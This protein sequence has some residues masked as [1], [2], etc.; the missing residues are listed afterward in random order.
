MIIA[1][2]IHVTGIVQGVGFRPFVYGLASRFGLC[3]WVINTSAGVDIHIEGMEANAHSF[4]EKL[5]SELP[6]LASLDL[7]TVNDASVENFSTFNIQPSNHIEGAFQPISPDVA[8]CADCE[9]ELFD[10][11]DRRYLYP[12]INCTNCGPRFTIIKDLP[13]D[14]PTTTMADFPMCD[15]CRAE[16]ENPLDRRFHAQPVACPNCGPLVQL[17]N[18]ASGHISNIEMRLTAILKTRQLLGR[19][20]SLRS[21]VWAGFIWLVMQ[22]MKTLSMNCAEEK[23]GRANL[24]R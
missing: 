15:D 4:I 22:R 9:R 2:H 6:P 19:G 1:K 7:I 5:S 11:N 21:K 20:R 12:F 10:P 14:R 16:Y 8:L 24:L 13:Y 17:R 23:A 3:G 18:P